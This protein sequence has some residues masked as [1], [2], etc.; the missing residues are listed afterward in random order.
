MFTPQHVTTGEEAAGE[1]AAES[2]EALPGLEPILRMITHVRVPLN[3]QTGHRPEPGHYIKLLLNMKEADD[4]SLPPKEKRY[5]SEDIH[6]DGVTGIILV[7]EE[8]FPQLPE[9]KKK[10]SDGVQVFPINGS[11]AS[12]ISE[13]VFPINGSKVSLIS[14]AALN[15][16]KKKGVPAVPLCDKCGN[17]SSI[18]V[19]H[20][21]LLDDTPI[22]WCRSCFD[23]Y[24]DNASTLYRCDMPQAKAMS[25]GSRIMQEYESVR[26]REGPERA[27]SE[28]IQLIEGLQEIIRAQKARNV[29]LGIQSRNNESCSANV[30]ADIPAEPVVELPDSLDE[31]GSPPATATGSVE[32]PW[33]PAT[34]SYNSPP[35]APTGHPP[36]PM[37]HPPELHEMLCSSG[38]CV[39]CYPPI[40]GPFPKCQTVGC[41]FSEHPYGTL[42]GCSGYCCYDCMKWNGPG[43]KGGWHGN[44]CHEHGLYGKGLM[45]WKEQAEV[46]R[47]P[48]NLEHR[49]RHDPRFK[50]HPG[51]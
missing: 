45:A 40:Q 34:C 11:E 37:G 18:R 44:E 43:K 10:I 31:L 46:C 6:D 49:R 38:Y 21:K 41:F 33:R 25:T 48:R 26:V 16:K 19:H 42:H 50:D 5:Y 8:E 4:T 23:K 7:N 39:K 29:F 36:E 35:Q 13:Q 30:P 28:M 14:E 47:D 12:L 1:T 27:S 20:H 22:M 3:D 24:F 32:E 15:R 51:F 9:P 17:K 2:A